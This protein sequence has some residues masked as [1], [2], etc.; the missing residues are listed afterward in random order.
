MAF[1]KQ[2]E[3]FCIFFNCFALTNYLSNESDIWCVDGDAREITR[4]C[5][6]IRDS[7]RNL[8]DAFRCIKH[9]AKTFLF[10]CFK[11][12]ALFRWNINACNLYF[13]SISILD[14]AITQITRGTLVCWRY[15]TSLGLG[16]CLHAQLKFFSF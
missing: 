10:K 7:V 13:N 6:R 16:H 4:V 12:H 9:A 2:I 11:M 14:I 5:L 3:I 1:R 15:E 8:Q